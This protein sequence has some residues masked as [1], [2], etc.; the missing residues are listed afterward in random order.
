MIGLHFKT[1]LLTINNITW[2]WIYFHSI[3]KNGIYT[4]FIGVLWFC[5]KKKIRSILKYLKKKFTFLL[6]STIC[7]SSLLWKK[8]GVKTWSKFFFST[9]R[10]MNRHLIGQWPLNGAWTDEW[11][12]RSY[13]VSRI[14][15]RYRVMQSSL[16][17]KVGRRANRW[18]PRR[19]HR[20]QNGRA[21]ELGT[22]FGVW[23]GGGQRV[24]RQLAL[25][26]GEH[27]SERERKR[28]RDQAIAA[29][30]PAGS[31]SSDRG[32]GR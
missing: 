6:S 5:S 30:T 25:I 3:L 18:P 20:Q 23:L 26:T 2:L 9:E 29:E 11:R 7:R 17:L 15:G 24:Y 4:V 19:G 14:G 8:W 27:A 21:G 16:G 22:G 12:P 10:N 1:Y 32:P 13:R 31:S 28:E